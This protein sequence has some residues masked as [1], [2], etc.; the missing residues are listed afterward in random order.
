MHSM[1]HSMSSMQL[2]CWIAYVSMI[3]VPT[4]VTIWGRRVS[5]SLASA[6]WSWRRPRLRSSR[7]LDHPVSSKARRAAAIARSMSAG[8][9]SATCPATSSVAGLT[10]A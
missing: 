2:S 4:S 10:L 9:A 8:P 7:S 6:S 1:S 5:R 3:G